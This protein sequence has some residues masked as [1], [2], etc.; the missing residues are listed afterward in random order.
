MKN[1]KEKKNKYFVIHYNIV[2]TKSCHNVYS[3]KIISKPDLFY[4]LKKNKLKFNLN[5]IKLCN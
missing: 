4:K 5:T 3:T 2:S 1:K